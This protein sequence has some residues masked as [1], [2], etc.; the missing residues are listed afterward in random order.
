[1]QISYY[2]LNKKSAFIDEPNSA[3]FIL[4]YLP[5]YLYQYLTSL[6]SQNLTKTH[7]RNKKH[8]K[9][10]KSEGIL[11]V[12]SARQNYRSRVFNL[13]KNLKLHKDLKKKRRRYWDRRRLFC[14]FITLILLIICIIAIILI[15]F[16]QKSQGKEKTYKYH[17]FP[18]SFSSNCNL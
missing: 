15:L 17:S 11:N 5:L 4:G 10:T 6:S 1:M 18:S 3:Q 16:L 2:C 9:T 13:P 12:Q 14:L 8:L 7:H